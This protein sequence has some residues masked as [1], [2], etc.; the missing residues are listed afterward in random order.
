M[1]K[2]VQVSREAG[3]H[4]RPT[5]LPF[6]PW[7][8]PDDVARIFQFIHDNDLTGATD[9]V[10]LSIKLL[11]PNGS[12]LADHP[13]LTPHLEAYDTQALTWRW[14]FANPDTEV[15]YK[16]LESIAASASDCGQEAAATLDEMRQAVSEM[17][18]YR[19]RSSTAASTAA[20]R[21]TESWFCC[22]EPTEGQSVS[23]LIGEQH[24]A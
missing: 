20:P 22:A 10:Q 23:I 12:L 19:I 9:P 4:I 15:L 14:R 18:G 24:R 21:L 16:E 13:A 1:E 5:W 8:T 3:V 2:A 6:F 17:V 11:L 7:T